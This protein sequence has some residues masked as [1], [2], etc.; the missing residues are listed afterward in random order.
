MEKD[1]VTL[2]KRHHKTDF[3]S[4]AILVKG[5]L[6]DCGHGNGYSPVSFLFNLIMFQVAIMHIIVG[7][8]RTTPRQSLH[9]PP[10]SLIFY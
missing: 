1:V 5:H 6:T 8:W 7:Q 9:G 10:Q 4:I 2:M 3:K